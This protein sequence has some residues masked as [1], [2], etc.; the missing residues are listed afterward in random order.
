MHG[1][2]VLITGGSRGLGLILAHEFGARGARG[3]CARERDSR[4][5]AA[6]PEVG[7]GVWQ[8]PCT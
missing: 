1:A 3:I 8:S 2:A 6:G 4:D 7:A 5:A